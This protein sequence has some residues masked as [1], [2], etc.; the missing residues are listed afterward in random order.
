MET[1]PAHRWAAISRSSG[2]EQRVPVLPRGIPAA[3]KLIRYSASLV[4]GFEYCA[5]FSVTHAQPQPE[6]AGEAICD[7]MVAR[8]RGGRI[9]LPNG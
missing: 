6:R 1:A 3:F 9:T 5:V 4:S 8:Y 2:R 7:P